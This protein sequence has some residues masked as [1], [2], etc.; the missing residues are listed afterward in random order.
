MLR[1]WFLSMGCLAP[2]GSALAPRPKT[3]P[4]RS[5]HL[6]SSVPQVVSAATGHSLQVQAVKKHLVLVRTLRLARLVKLSR[7]SG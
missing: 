3:I 2:C 6:F 1:A 7:V 4:P 5:P